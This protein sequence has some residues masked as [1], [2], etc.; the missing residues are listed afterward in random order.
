[1]KQSTFTIPPRK[2][3]VEY[4]RLLESTALPRTP[5]VRIRWWR[6]STWMLDAKARGHI[7]KFIG[8][9]IERGGRNFEI[10]A[11]RPGE[12]F[13]DKFR[14]GSEFKPYLPK[15]DTQ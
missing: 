12:G 5:L 2:D 7:D 11:L 15:E 1:M 9:E 10:K 3:R 13:E 6:G 8:E 4:Q 14:G